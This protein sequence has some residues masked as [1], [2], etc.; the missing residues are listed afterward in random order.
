[1][2]HRGT[3]TRGVVQCCK[4][5]QH[6][7]TGG[8]A[9]P[10]GRAARTHGGWCNAATPRSTDTREVEQCRASSP[11]SL[12][13]TRRGCKAPPLRLLEHAHLPELLE[14]LLRELLGAQLRQL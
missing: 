4:A 2:T 3:D 12:H 14:A 10:R 13:S 7:H 9:M 11:F 5:S 8:V 1:M 6:G